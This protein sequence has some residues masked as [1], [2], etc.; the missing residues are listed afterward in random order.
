MLKNYVDINKSIRMEVLLQ[1]C[2]SIPWT[3][4]KLYVRYHKVIYDQIFPY[5]AENLFGVS[6]NFVGNKIVFKKHDLQRIFYLYPDTKH[7]SPWKGYLRALS[8]QFKW[9][10]SY[11][12]TWR[13]LV[14]NMLIFYTHYTKKDSLKKK[15]KSKVSCQKSFANTIIF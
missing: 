6:F 12:F 9:L 14:L 5:L 3:S 13:H 4:S 15:K 2:H 8:R 7:I 11:T 10:V 1:H